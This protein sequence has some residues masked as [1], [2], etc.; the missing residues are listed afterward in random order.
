MLRKTM[1]LLDKKA[2]LLAEGRRSLSGTAQLLGAEDGLGLDALQLAL[3][4]ANWLVKWAVCLS[5]DS[6]E[7]REHSLSALQLYNQCSVDAARALQATPTG[8]PQDGVLSVQGQL[9]TAFTRHCDALLRRLEDPGDPAAAELPGAFL[10]AVQEPSASQSAKATAAAL[11]VRCFVRGLR[12]GN[13]YC[14]QRVLRMV[15]IIS[16]Y[17]AETEGIL[18]QELK[19]IPAWVFLQF[20][21]QLMGCLDRPEGAVVSAILEHTAAAYPG[22]LYYPFRITSEFLGPRGRERSARV[23]QLLRDPAQDAFIEALGGLTHPEHRWNDGMKEIDGVLRSVAAAGGSVTSLDEGAKARIAALYQGLRRRTLETEWQHVGGK[24]GAY[25]R[26]W[27]R[28][29][30]PIADKFAGP[31]GE[32]LLS[33]GKKALDALREAISNAKFS[34]EM[35]FAGGK[36]PLAE[37]SQ[38]LRDFDPLACRIEM[39]GQHSVLSAH[40]GGSGSERLYGGPKARVQ[41][42]IVA[43]DP[44]LLVMTSI[45]KPKR[46]RLF[47][48]AGGQHMFLVK[49]GEDLRNDERIQQL[50]Q[51][52]NGVVRAKL[53]AGTGMGAGSGAEDGAG[54]EDFRG[55]RTRTYA[56][57]P[58]TS[59][60]CTVY[61]VSNQVY[62]A[63][64]FAST[65]FGCRWACWSG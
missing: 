40:S 36:V 17:P 51:L 52:M 60:V 57:I 37:F 46:V 43:V 59:Q 49:G 20:A 48:S 64:Y 21:A 28:N 3:L 10:A 38:W 45:R 53:Q 19:H 54:L 41:E 2:E 39:P 22:A 1:E 33:G 61:S 16:A 56:V 18:R 34:G 65:L 25:N 14:M 35:Q 31:A 13:A 44:A 63:A 47:G 50:F 6:T 23:A 12:I 11:A 7:A 29:A 62:S 9:S 26:Q 4:R 27:A 30:R 42:I 24:I 55:L 8:A 15:Q 5:P 58:M 32:K